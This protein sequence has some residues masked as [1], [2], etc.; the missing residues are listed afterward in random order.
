MTVNAKGLSRSQIKRLE[1][2]DLC[3]SFLGGVQRKGIVEHFGVSS[4]AATRDLSLYREMHSRNMDYDKS[5]KEYSSLEG[6]KA[7]Y[8]HGVLKVFSLLWDM[9]VVSEKPNQI[10]APNLETI[11]QISRAIHL[12]KAV[13]MRYWSLGSGCTEREFV[14]SVLVDNGL[15][16]HVRGYDRKRKEFRD[17]VVNR[18]ECTKILMGD[19]VQSDE[20]KEADN[21]W[22]RI[23]EMELV[24]HPG[25][26]CKETI[27]REYNMDDGAVKINVRAAVAGYFLRRW[28]VDC[29]KNYTGDH[30]VYHLWL[31][32][33]LSLYGASNLEI[34]P[35][36]EHPE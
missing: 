26:Q 36:Y 5:R 34:A 27:I 1:Y 32:N 6:F 15:R 30:K 21:Q 2:I 4:A 20:L 29:S 10:N 9:G 23:V 3:L 24:P 11:A 25:L 7:A 18:I 31:R 19:L 14:P 8:S 35:E 33:S 12:K 13:E 17:F 16:W 28:N 22:N